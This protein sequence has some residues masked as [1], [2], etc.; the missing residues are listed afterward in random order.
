MNI[1]IIIFIFLFGLIIGSFLNCL[2]WRLHKE[3]SIL[4]RSYC[5]KCRHQIVWYDNIPVFS[6]LLL[7][8]KCRHCGKNISWQYPLVELATGILFV[9]SFL[10]NLSGM[11][12]QYLNRQL[13]DN[14]QTLLTSYFLLLTLKDW[15]LIS[16]M[17]VIFIY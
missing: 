7:K 4:G 9:M 15:F 8:G 17:L 1:L 13:A 2:I 16:V 5:P 14:P 10:A 6:F 11:D 3:E 12:W